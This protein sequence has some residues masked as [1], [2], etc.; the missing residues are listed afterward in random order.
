VPLDPRTPVIV[1]VGQLTRRP[2]DLAQAAEPAE[3]MADVLRRAEA[4]AGGTRPVLP[5]IDSIRVVQ[6][7]SWRYGDPGAAV[8]ERLGIE[9]RETLT[10]VTGGNTP[11]MLVNLTC[12]EIQDGVLDVA[13][14]VG[15]EAIY[16]RWRARRTETHLEWSKQKDGA[17]PDRVIGE[18]RS[19]SHDA[20]LSLGL[21]A[22]VQLYPLFENALRAAASE[23][24]DEHQVKISELW[25]RFSDIAARNPY[26]WQQQRR[27]AEEI[28]TP[29]GDN[30]MIGFPYPKLMNSNIDVDQGAGLIICS[31]EAARRL[32]VPADRW[33][34]PHSGADGHDKWFLSN[35]IDFTS[36][37]A[38]RIGVGKALELAGIGVERFDYVDL[39]S[40][41]PSAVQVAAAELG[42]A[43]ERPL[44]V[45]GGLCFAGGP[46]NNYVTHSIATMVERL[47]EDPDAF[48][49][50][51]AVGWYLTK[52]AF[53]IYSSQPPEP[54]FRHAYVQDE[55]DMT[56]ARE[57]VT[58]Y[59]GSATIET[60]TVMHDREGAPERG[61]A[62]CLTPAGTRA[63]AATSD[64]DLMKAMTVEEFCG[65][66]VTIGADAT[67]EAD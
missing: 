21:A 62:A 67:V 52:H 27:T 45:T 19:G 56:P 8:A 24:I 6:V 2:D 47:R 41:F 66:P 10:T 60:Y 55:L 5:A 38:V 23:G 32:G 50:C 57:V 40:C 3:M 54:G 65:R 39:Y 7:V 37:P 53:G 33:V 63:W 51:S 59:E 44:T 31:V 20:E 11:Q 16:T 49:L 48:G 28:R 9:P 30:R 1:G 43:L 12:R 14:V 61:F 4:D 29:G 15:A 46:V 26:A 17:V 13:A 22:P 18:E 42:L 64:P 35:R 58:G 36:S 25:A 34:F